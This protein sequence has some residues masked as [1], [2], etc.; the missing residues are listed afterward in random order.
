MEPFSR[1]RF[2]QST[3]GQG[4]VFAAGKA[5]A[6]PQAERPLNRVLRFGSVERCVL[7]RRASKNV[8]CGTGA[9]KGRGA[10]VDKPDLK[11]MTLQHRKK[12]LPDAECY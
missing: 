5:A 12:G 1:L 7:L 9:I 11:K 4:G 6:K 3:R 2:R 10:L 8:N